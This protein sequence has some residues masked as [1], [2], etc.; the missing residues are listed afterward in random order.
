[1]RNELTVEGIIRKRTIEGVLNRCKPIYM[2][3]MLSYQRSALV[4]NTLL[5][6]LPTFKLAKCGTVCKNDDRRFDTIIA[7]V[8]ATRYDQYRCRVEGFL[9]EIL[10]IQLMDTLIGTDYNLI[11]DLIP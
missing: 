5:H 8:I 4:A 1:M 3:L 7:Y 2:Y 6:P 11:C 10:L 9:Q